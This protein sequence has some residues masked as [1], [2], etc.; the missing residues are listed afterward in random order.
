VLPVLMSPTWR[1]EMNEKILLT[2]A[3]NATSSLSRFARAYV[4]TMLGIGGAVGS[5]LFSLCMKDQHPEVSVSLGIAAF[6]ALVTMFG[7]A[8]PVAVVV[9]VLCL[10]FSK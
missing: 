10:A 9:G 8:L 5:V 6:G 2:L 7:A 3:A 1:T 4:F